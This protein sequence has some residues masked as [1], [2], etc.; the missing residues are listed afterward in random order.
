MPVDNQLYNRAGDIWWSEDE[1]LSMLHTMLNPVRVAYFRDVLGRERKGDGSGR[2]L[3]VGSGGGVL[4]EEL[5]RLGLR[6]TGIDPARAA[7]ATARKHAAESGLEI[8]YAAG[9]GEWLP[10]AGGSYDVAVCCD[11]LEHVGDPARVIGEIARVLK[12]GGLF[13]YETINRTLRSRI[14]VIGAFQKWRWTSCAPPDLHDWKQF[15]KPRELR[16][17]ME[18]SGLEHGGAAGISPRANPLELVRQMRKRKRGEIS[19]GEL[20]RRMKMEASRDLSMSYLGW[21]RKRRAS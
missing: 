15:I 17:M 3:D 16:A 2:A 8:F 6:V 13:F 1:H 4:A 18:R 21:A 7:V 5:A 19:Q 11:V 12:P 10:F 14:G 9:A 20:G